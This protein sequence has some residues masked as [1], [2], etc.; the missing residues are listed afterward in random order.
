MN[1]PTVER[2]L[3]AIIVAD[4]VGYSRMM[5]DDEAGT[6]AALTRYRREFVDPTILEHRGRIVKTTGDGLLL[7]FASAVDAARCAIALQ[8]G[9]AEINAG[10]PE[11]RRITFRI[12]VNIGD[13]IVQDHDLFGD[14][15]NVA[16]RL[17]AFAEPGG[18]CVSRAANDQIQGKIEASFADAGSHQ[19]KNI[20]RPVEVLALSAEAI[21]GMPRAAAAAGSPRSSTGETRLWPRRTAIIAVLVV[22]LCLAGAA[23]ALFLGRNAK[24]D[25]SKELDPILSQAL[26]KS[27]TKARRTLISEYVA[28]GPHRA[29]ALA[30]KAQSRWWTGDW[31]TPETAEEKVLERCQLT[32]DEPCALLAVDEAIIAAGSDGSRASRDM[33]RIHYSGMFDPAQVPGVRLATSARVDVTGYAAAPGPK[34]AAIHARGLLILATGASSQR[35]AEEQALKNCNDDPS[36]K[37]VDG[38]C[39]LYAADNRVV[40]TERSTTPI[41]P[42]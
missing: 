32:F 18:I 29:F 37:A 22:S 38:P 1:E 9:M 41:S 33:P 42:P 39:Y 23:A 35:Q 6:L 17:Q 26:P 11:S 27:T 13:V 30:P 12:G 28:L 4:V 31:P 2:K 5:G 3:A 21:A 40:L 16:A 7:E 36:R 8:Q 15:V 24:K 34:A 19:F 10:L 25:L 20:A 14:G